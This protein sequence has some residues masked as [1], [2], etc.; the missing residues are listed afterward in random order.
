[1][2]SGVSHHADAHPRDT[3]G[4]EN[5]ELGDATRSVEPAVANIT[6]YA[7]HQ[8]SFSL[9]TGRVI[10][11]EAPPHATE[12]STA[13]VPPASCTTWATIASP[14][15]LPGSDRAEGDR[16]KRSKMRGFSTDGTPEI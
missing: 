7:W 6:S 2:S 13:I 12:S 14:S 1:M 11:K 8:T 4:T 10:T 9:V 16:Q 15:P 5:K 3:S